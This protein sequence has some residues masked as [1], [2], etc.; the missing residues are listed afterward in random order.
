MTPAQIL[1]GEVPVP[2]QAPRTI[3]HNFDLPYTWQT[4]VGFQKQLGTLWGFESDLLYWKETNTPRATDPNQ[5][6][7]PVTGYNIRGYLDPNFTRIRYIES[8]GKQDYLA[9]SSGLRRRFRD[10][11][12]INVTHTWIFYKNDDTRGWFDFPNNT[13][14]PDAEWASSL[15]FQVNTFRLNGI[16]QLPY[17][18]AVSGRLLLRLRTPLRYDNR[19]SAVRKEREQE[20]PE[21]RGSDPG[22]SGCSGSLRRT[23]HDRDRSRQR[24][25]EECA[26]GRSASQD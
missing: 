8:T 10:N 4:S 19:R 18:F 23:L 20:S 9:V 12:Q 14:D 6:Y 15:D 3:A 7:D 17:D 24:G 11:F 25:A 16:Y 2:P 22:E 13:F 5:I 26:A 21:S 1:A